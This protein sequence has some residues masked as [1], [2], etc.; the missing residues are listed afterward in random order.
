[1]ILE[2]GCFHCRGLNDGGTDALALA[3]T[4]T[5]A[6]RDAIPGG[7]ARAKFDV[8]VNQVDTR[9][10][11]NKG[12]VPEVGAD[13]TT[14]VAHEVVA[15]GVVGVARQRIIVKGSVESEVL[16]ADSSQQLS[17]NGLGQP[18]RPDCIDSVE[19][20]PIGLGASVERLTRPPSELPFDPQAVQD[21]EICTD[22]GV[23]AASERGEQESV[24]GRG[25]T[26]VTVPKP[27][28]ASNCWPWAVF[29]KKQN[30]KRTAMKASFFN[31]FSEDWL[32]KLDVNRIG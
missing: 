20:W 12:V 14:E 28:A 29:S 22:A 24:R 3:S 2:D 6:Q 19:D 31:F 15:A 10:R 18:R 32:K 16:A 13:A 21:Q 9:F 8:V 7:I 23:N 1:M 4:E 27:K 11:P 5:I 30:T 17:R 26:D 25:G